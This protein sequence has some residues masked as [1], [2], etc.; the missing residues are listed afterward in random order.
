MVRV[1]SVK[2]SY[3]SFDVSFCVVAES[4]AKFAELSD[5]TIT[6]SV[7]CLVDGKH[8]VNGPGPDSA[9]SLLDL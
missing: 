1:M 5:V 7:Q 9:V 6:S 2:V 4:L 8:S 3:A